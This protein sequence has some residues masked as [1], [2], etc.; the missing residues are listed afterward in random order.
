MS[1]SARPPSILK[2]IYTHNPFYA[3]SASLMMFAVLKAYGT[4]E[5]GTINTWIM[6]GV[7]AGY[8]LVLAVIGVLIVRRGKVWEDARS[9]LLLLLVLF[10]AV[11]I[12][13]DD[14]F[15]RATSAGQGAGLLLGGYL[16]SAVVSEAVLR[17]AGIRLGLA[18]RIPY[19][20]MMALFYVVPW[21]C[22]PE[23]NIRKNAAIEW[24]LL[25]FPTAAAVLFLTLLPAVRRGPK[26]VANNGTPW[27]WPTFPWI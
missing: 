23:F 4:I 26:Y 16:F 10:V 24:T 19:H 25:L 2:Y 27:P 11:S 1:E 15:V 12:C 14:L 18:Y 8:T 7:L 6:A 17:G 13:A 9:I 20:L 5:V 22:S 21:W 3:I